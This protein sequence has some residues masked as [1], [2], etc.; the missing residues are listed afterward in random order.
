[1]GESKNKSSGCENE[2]VSFGSC[3]DYI[4]LA[5]RD[6]Q[7]IHARVVY[8]H[9]FEEGFKCIDFPPRVFNGVTSEEPT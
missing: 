1:M 9:V 3:S 2:T 4:S 7:E 5:F 8:L 6:I